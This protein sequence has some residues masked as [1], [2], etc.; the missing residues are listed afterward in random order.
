MINVDSDLNVPIHCWFEGH[1]SLLL[2][3]SLCEL[4]IIVG[5]VWNNYL[6]LIIWETHSFTPEFQVHLHV[7]SQAVIQFASWL[8]PPLFS[9]GAL[10]VRLLQHLQETPLL[11]CG[12]EDIWEYHACLPQLHIHPVQTDHQLIMAFPDPWAQGITTEWARSMRCCLC[13]PL[14]LVNWGFSSD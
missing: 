2:P 11:T 12:S 8:R 6:V 14:G 7:A 1:Q 9:V 4:Y 13:P 3:L 5:F 10:G